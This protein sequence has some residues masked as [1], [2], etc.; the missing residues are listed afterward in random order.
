MLINLITGM[1]ILAWIAG[2]LGLV[3]IVFMGIA[4]L[5]P[6]SVHLSRVKTMEEIS[7]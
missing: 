6:H 4:A 3:G 7:G 2:G 5:A 1:A